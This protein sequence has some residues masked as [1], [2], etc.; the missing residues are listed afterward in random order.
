LNVDQR[1][2][3]GYGRAYRDAAIGQWGTGTYDDVKAAARW[4]GARPDIDRSRIGVMGLSFGGYLALLGLVRDPGLFAAGINLM[5]VVDRRGR[6]AGRNT[7]F[8]VG[9]TEAEDPELWARISPIT[10]IARLR[11]P[12]LILHADQDRNVSVEQT[13]ILVD[14]L[15]RLG[16]DH[17]VRIYQ[18]EAHGLADPLNQLDSY[19]RILAFLDRHLRGAGGALKE[20]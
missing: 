16:K 13:H 17:E 4:L 3:S 5:G 15:E 14:E 12:L 8:H 11:A 10:Q 19:Q 18:G 2:S 7:L 6:F 1:G 9:P 20:E